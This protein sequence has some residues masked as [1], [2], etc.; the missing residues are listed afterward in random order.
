MRPR[1]EILSSKDDQET[2]RKTAQAFKLCPSP[3]R[4]KAWDNILAVQELLSLDRRVAILD[5]GCRSGILLTW[6][7]QLGFEHLWG[8]DTRLPFPPLRVSL[9]RLDMQTFFACSSL[10]V[11]HWRRLRRAAAEHLPFADAQ[12]EIVTCMSVLEHG[13]NQEQFLKEVWRLLKPS[14]TLILSTDYWHEATPR[15]SRLFAQPDVI[16]DPESIQKFLE[17]ASSAGFQVPRLDPRPDVIAEPPIEFDGAR[18][19]FLYMVLTKPNPSQSS[20]GEHSN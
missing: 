5:V 9:Q 13:V 15:S 20:S 8:V 1:L 4:T 14:G 10:L 3:D 16:F 19:T 12:F 11:Q 7:N 17:L 2:A 6:L 18:Y